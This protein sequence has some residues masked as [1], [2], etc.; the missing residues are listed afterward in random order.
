MSGNTRLTITL[1]SHTHAVI[2]ELAKLQGRPKSK[3]ITELLDT[4]VPVLERTCYV[5]GIA[6]RA[7]AGMSDDFKASLER[8]EAKVMQMMN[9][10]M[11][12]MDMLA[13]D[14]SGPSTS[15]DEAGRKA[16]WAASPASRSDTTLPPHSNTGVTIG[17]NSEKPSKNKH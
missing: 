7:S 13:T 12:Q 14:L 3:V 1:N 16:G 8:S 17:D 2:A 11:S 4:T 9:E 6:Q 15:G 10:A 5:L